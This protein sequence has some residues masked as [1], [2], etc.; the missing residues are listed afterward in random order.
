MDIA[1]PPKRAKR[2]IMLTPLIDKL[3]ITDEKTR[4]IL[5]RAGLREKPLTW[6]SW[7]MWLPLNEEELAARNKIK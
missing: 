1:T 2:P 3:L 6:S 5:K 7:E 4:G